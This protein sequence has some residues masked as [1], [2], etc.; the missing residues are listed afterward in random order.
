MQSLSCRKG[1]K[2]ISIFY[3]ASS[4]AM[5]TPRETIFA[6]GCRRG[7]ALLDMLGVFAEFE[8]NGAGRL[9]RG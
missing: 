5:Y 3:S 9:Q 6:E 8:T 4:H 2:S 7:K 1:A